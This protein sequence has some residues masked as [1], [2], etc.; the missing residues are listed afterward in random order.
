VL[1]DLLDVHRLA[2]S[3]ATSPVPGIGPAVANMRRWLGAM[4]LPDGDV[5]LFNDCTLVG[6]D[7]VRA[8]GAAPP[9]VGE[10]V[11]VLQPSG[12]VVVRRGRLHMVA[13]VGPPC[14]PNLPAHAHAD[15]LSF[16]LA[17]DGRRLIVDSGTST[18]APG[19]RRGLERSTAAHNT[20]EVDGADSTEV[21][22]VF[23]AARLSRA[24]LE[25]VGVEGD[26]N[27]ITASHD[28]YRRLPGRPVHR[29]RWAVG[30]DAVVV[31]DDVIGSGAHRAVFRLHVAPGVP[32]VARDGAATVGPA[33]VRTS[34]DLVLS[35]VEVASG[36][37]HCAPTTV[38]SM[39]SEGILPLRLQT[40]LT[41]DDVR[42]RK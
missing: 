21:W 19:R 27:V 13:D 37:G 22:G 39:T 15:C 18:Y 17:V 25:W 9:P 36:F 32:V 2:E 8:L 3:A 30:D 4:L 5:P 42:S 26:R 28:G 35:D 12:Y 31:D 16:E 41:L 29:R 23:R 24:Q 34:G 7:R 20:V 14:P 40:T 11:T 10:R 33:T 1:G 38:L 6:T